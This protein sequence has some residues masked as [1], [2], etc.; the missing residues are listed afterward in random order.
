MTASGCTID[1]ALEIELGRGACVE[2]L[3]L[4]GSRMAVGAAPTA[5]GSAP[6]AGLDQNETFHVNVHHRGV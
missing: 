1:R 4:N 6:S 3:I 5:G 2:E